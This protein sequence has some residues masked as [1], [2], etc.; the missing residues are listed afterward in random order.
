MQYNYYNT[1]RVPSAGKRIK[2]YDYILRPSF[3]SNQCCGIGIVLM[4]IRIRIQV[5]LS[6][7]IPI[8]TLIPDPTPSLQMLDNLEKF[9]FIHTISNKFFLSFSSAS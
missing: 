6:I 4:P 9:T 8:L 7:L 2:G 1:V 3:K 5:R